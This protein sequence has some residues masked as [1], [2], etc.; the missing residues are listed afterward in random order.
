MVIMLDWP[1]LLW[2][3]CANGN[4]IVIYNFISILKGVCIVKI[5]QFENGLVQCWMDNGF[6][7]F[8]EELLVFDVH[9]FL[10][11]IIPRII[12]EVSTLNC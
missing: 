1:I 4:L 12:T 11:T 3:K 5:L 10:G 2:D 6:V 7:M 9:N 8:D